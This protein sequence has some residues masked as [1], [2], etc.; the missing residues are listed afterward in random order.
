MIKYILQSDVTGT[1]MS[2]L[3]LP[4]SSVEEYGVYYLGE[5]N[6]T[7]MGDDGIEH[8][9]VEIRFSYKDEKGIVRYASLDKETF[10]KYFCKSI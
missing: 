2:H 8:Y 9:R 3:A 4:I 5:K 6:V 10:E 1:Q 7:K